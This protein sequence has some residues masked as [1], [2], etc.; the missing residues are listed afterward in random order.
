[1][2]DYIKVILWQSQSDYMT[3]ISF[4]ECCSQ[5]EIDIE[6]LQTCQE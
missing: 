3:L 1:M 6:D 4:L 2:Y 5:L